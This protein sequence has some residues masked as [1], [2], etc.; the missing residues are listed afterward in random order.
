M[1]NSVISSQL[2]VACIRALQVIYTTADQSGLGSHFGSCLVFPY[3]LH[4]SLHFFFTKLKRKNTL[5]F[6][7]QLS[8]YSSESMLA[9]IQGLFKTL[10]W[11][12]TTFQ[13]FLAFKDFSR[14]YSKIQGLFKTVRTLILLANG[15]ELNLILPKFACPLYFFFSSGFLA[16]P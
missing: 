2:H 10:S 7:I 11:N 8:W 6:T 16:L 9:K 13:G 15:D 12:S 4:N 3:I 5:I 14:I 1:F